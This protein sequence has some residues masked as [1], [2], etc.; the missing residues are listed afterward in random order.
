MEYSI[1]KKRNTIYSKV[2]LPQKP[3]H[4]FIAI[5]N[6]GFQLKVKVVLENNKIKYYHEIPIEL[7]KEWK[8]V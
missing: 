1:M 5:L 3:N 4:E 2:F 8:R 6:N 7:I